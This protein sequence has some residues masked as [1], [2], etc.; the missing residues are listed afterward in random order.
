MQISATIEWI[1]G[2]PQLIRPLSCPML[3]L[4]Y[5]ATQTVHIYSYP[6]RSQLLLNGFREYLSSS[7]HWAALWWP[8][9]IMPPRLST[10]IHIHADLSY[11]WMDSGNISAH[12]SIELPYDGPCIS[13]HPGCPYIDEHLRLTII[14]LCWIQC[15]TGV[16]EPAHEVNIS[17]ACTVS[18]VYPRGHINP[19][20]LWS[21]LLHR[22]VCLMIRGDCIGLGSSP[23]PIY[24]INM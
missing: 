3:A 18:F 16:A 10:Y 17:V 20:N 5:H 24:A 9:D 21:P 15:D 12:P 19:L 11:Y 7:V 2:I 13:C 14:F 23:R 22:V 4:G 1:P 6:C 8:L